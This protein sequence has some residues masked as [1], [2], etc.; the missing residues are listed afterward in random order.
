MSL[1]ARLLLLLATVTA[2]VCLT[3][4]TVYLTIRE[5]EF[6]RQRVALAHQQLATMVE[7]AH[8]ASRYSGEISEVLLL[9]EEEWPEFVAARERLE[10]NLLELERAT[11]Q[12]VSFLEG[13]RPAEA[14]TETEEFDHIATLRRLYG[15]IDRSV[16]QLVLLQ[17][18]G[19]RA[20]AL[21]VFRAGIE[22]RLDAEFQ[23]LLAE[24][25]AG[26]HEEVAEAQAAADALSRQLTF[27]LVAVAGL[28]LA[29]CTAAALWLNRSLSQ[30]IGRLMQGAAAIGRGDLAHRIA[31]AGRDELAVLS[32]AFNEMADRIEDQQQRLVSIQRD[33]ESQVRARTQELERANQRLQ[34]LDRSRVRFLADISHEL[35]TPLTILR[36]EAEVSLRG[37]SR[38][39]AE[40]RDALAEIVDQAAQMSRLIDDLLFL[41]RSEADTISF[42]A[43]PVVLQDCLAEAIAAGNG[44]ITDGLRLE[45]SWPDAPIRVSADPQR[46]QQA[47]VILIDN[48]IKYSEGADSVEVVA[49]RDGAAA[50]ISVID[51]GPGIPEEDLPYV[52]ERFYRG[53]GRASDAGG[54]GLGLSIARWIVEKHGGTI[55]ATSEPHRRTAFTIRLPLEQAA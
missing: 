34:H 15:E 41:A 3:A 40:Y 33:L 9:G 26:E 45:H 46:L 32:R 8:A 1:K 2:A 13:R 28:G 7:L 6:Y 22:S 17:D 54:S 36:G 48:A 11:R 27:V 10:E 52:F 18:S 42:E 53:S 4:A 16:E 5:T 24:G 44:L 20:D 43:R 49:R 30:S 25:I 12:E 51:H 35:R 38:P 23:R 14:T 19:R 29:A 55:S 39:E 37:T 31:V 47:V 50:E 21:I